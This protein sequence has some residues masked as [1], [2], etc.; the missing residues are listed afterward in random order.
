MSGPPLLKL[1]PRSV[2]AQLAPWLTATTFVLIAAL[3][4]QTALHED[5][6]RAEAG[7]SNEARVALQTLFS[8]LQDGEIGQRGYVVTGDRAFLQPYVD[9]RAH[10]PAQQRATT[11]LL[12][13]GPNSAAEVQNLNR[14][15]GRRFA[16]L[17][18]TIA[19]F[20]ARGRDSAAEVIATGQ[21]KQVMD[22]IRRVVARLS[23]AEVRRLD[24]RRGARNASR[25][26]INILGAAVL[27]TLMAL[28]LL[29]QWRDSRHNRQRSELL[30]QLREQA[31]RADAIFDS[32][33]DAIL[34]LNPSGSIETINGAGERMFGYA[35]AELLRRDMSVLTDV[36]RKRFGTFIEKLQAG[37]AALEQGIV[38]ELNARRKDGTTFPVDV[39]LRGMPLPDGLH[40]VAIVRD[41]S[42]R[43][44]VEAMKEE[45]ASTVSHELRTPLTSIV[46]AL[47]LLKGGAGGVLPER[48]ARLV[49]IAESN[50]VRLVRLI[51][52][53]LDL[54]KFAS[55]Q[56]AFSPSSESLNALAQRAA[57]MMIGLSE[58]RR[59]LIAVTPSSAEPVV[60]ADPDRVLQVLANLLSN[61]L[62]FSP[63]D[64][65]IEVRVEALADH[66]CVSVI[67]HG[68]G[69]PEAFRGR[70]FEK[71][72]QADGSD[73]RRHGGTGL[74][75][76]ISREIAD[77]H[78][79]ALVH[80]P[81]PGGGATFRLDLP[82]A[83][84]AIAAEDRSAG[85]RLLLCEDHPLMAEM[86][87]GALEA[88][89]YEVDVANAAGEAHQA[90]HTRRYAALLLDLGLPDANG[91]T[92]VRALRAAPGTRDLPI[93]V[94]SGTVDHNGDG[95]LLDLVD[96]LEKPVD[97]SRLRAALQVVL[98]RTPRASPVI[99]HVDD[100]QD[101]LEVARGVLGGAGEVVSTTS[102][103]E[104]RRV[105]A[106][107]R[108]DVVVLDLGLPDGS[109][110]E[111]IPE[112]TKPDG[113]PIPVIIYTAQDA[114]REFD[115]QVISVFTKSRVGLQHLA[116]AVRKIT[117]GGAQ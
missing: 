84:A 41:I 10:L 82:L 73:S 61:A 85:K 100:D 17:A 46:G 2:L 99:L 7:R 78:G 12:L 49:H 43:R 56:A 88:L 115:R 22:E 39:A 103:A 106:A 16:L 108:P 91:L 47:G 59:V 70:L 97:L 28:V 117:E 79:G 95:P 65:R 66:A 72:A 54:E 23:T 83:V 51:N 116:E 77:L 86:M 15:I 42:E 44:R 101:L 5:S 26:R 60:R 58:E 90:L 40:V 81:T 27:L 111:L 80:L 109:G 55:G 45:F 11:A 34:T 31:T 20:D 38:R 21:G 74:G 4:V 3:F 92:L 87:K 89:G 37:D 93:I 53:I 105:L 75:L 67:D 63:A 50:G 18:R 94:V 8:T 29:A 14:L 96:W 6:L 71:F 62:K 1:T 25:E 114:S 52:D 110:V 98:E 48:A 112:L 35:R 113:D 76:A 102:L 32:A 36:A 33:M 9:A 68:P 107:R 24:E 104:A 30:T 13:K 69:V 19:I 57:E 64:T